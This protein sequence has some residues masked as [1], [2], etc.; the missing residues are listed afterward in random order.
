MF[1]IETSLA[2]LRAAVEADEQTAVL[3]ILE[4]LGDD[5]AEQE[6]RGGPL[7]A[8]FTDW[9]W[10]RSCPASREEF[11]LWLGE[12]C[13][14]AVPQAHLDMAVEHLANMESR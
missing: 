2:A 8:E 3:S 1:E 5:R 14:H 4:R 9:C 12:I 6:R 11:H 7:W 13:D 10:A